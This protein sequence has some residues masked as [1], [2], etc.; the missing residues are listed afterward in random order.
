MKITRPDRLFARLLG[1]LFLA[2]LVTALLSFDKVEGGTATV[3]LVLGIVSLLPCI[4][5]CF[6]YDTK[7]R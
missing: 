6:Q 7:T 5:W 1:L 2:L 3:G 4:V